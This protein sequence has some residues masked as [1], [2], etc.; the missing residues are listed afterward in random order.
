MLKSFWSII[1]RE[2][3]N[4]SNIRLDNYFKPHA[5]G[6]KS[7]SKALE[8]MNNS[9]TTNHQQDDQDII[10]CPGC[11]HEQPE[12]P[13]FCADCGAPLTAFS[14]VGPFERIFAQGH[15]LRRSVSGPSSKIV[16]A[17]MWLLILP[18]FILLLSVRDLSSIAF[19]LIL[20]TIYAILLYRVTKNYLSHRNTKGASDQAVDPNN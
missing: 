17:G 20:G 5:R 10:V 7:V 9:S 12:G 19:L 13:H 1:T 18:H 16:V 8:L 14:T 4:S 2:R 3:D 6:L 15:A 11:L